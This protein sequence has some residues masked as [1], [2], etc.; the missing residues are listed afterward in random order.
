MLRGRHNPDAPMN[1]KKKKMVNSVKFWFW[2]WKFPESGSS[3]PR[4]SSIPREN[5]IAR[6]QQACSMLHCG[7]TR[8]KTEKTKTTPDGATLLPYDNQNYSMKSIVRYLCINLCKN[9]WVRFLDGNL[10]GHTF[11]G[12]GTA[13][14]QKSKADSDDQLT[15]A[16]KI[17]FLKW[18][19][20]HTH[21]YA[22]PS[23]ENLPRSLVRFWHRIDSSSATNE[24]TW[25]R[26]LQFANTFN[27]S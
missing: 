20:T 15:S 3:H 25:K 6:R 8:T 22:M 12:W 27:R 11:C 24:P 26:K 19:H 4:W 10:H 18:K 5:S 14:V 13:A 9:Y 16:P 17:L 7:R 21:I 23:R 1:L 2:F